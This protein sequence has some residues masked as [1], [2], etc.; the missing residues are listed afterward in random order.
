MIDYGYLIVPTY[1]FVTLLVP[2]L[3]VCFWK[4]KPI[5]AMAVAILIYVLL[6]AGSAFFL[7][8]HAM[9]LGRSFDNVRPLEITPRVVSN[10]VIITTGLAITGVPI[11][12]LIQWISRRRYRAKS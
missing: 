7:S 3:L 5:T 2:A 4:S 10:T 9:A 1:L 11:L 12:L 8:L 6:V